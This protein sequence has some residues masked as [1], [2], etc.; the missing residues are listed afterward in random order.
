LSSRRKHSPAKCGNWQSRIEGTVSLHEDKVAG[1][2][3]MVGIWSGRRSRVAF[4]RAEGEKWIGK[5]VVVVVRVERRVKRRESQKVGGCL[6]IFGERN[7]W[8]AR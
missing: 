8:N 6:G 7:R 3:A 2:A 1:S 5:A 4:V